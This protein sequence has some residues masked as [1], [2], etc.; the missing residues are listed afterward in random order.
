[1]HRRTTLTCHCEEAQP[2]R[3]RPCPYNDLLQNTKNPP[4]HAGG[5]AVL[6][7]REPSRATNS[8]SRTNAAATHFVRR[9]SFASSVPALPLP[10]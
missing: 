8:V 4:A 3:A 1:M 9:E 6:S 2:G 10:R 5:L 7:Y